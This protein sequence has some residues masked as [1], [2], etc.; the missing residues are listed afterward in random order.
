[1]LLPPPPSSWATV[2]GGA[3]LARPTLKTM[4]PDTGCPSP[5]HGLV[6]AEDDLGGRLAHRRA[7][8]RDG[9]LE[10]RVGRRGRRRR[11][12]QG[13]RE[14]RGASHQAST[15]AAPAAA[16]HYGD[17][18]QRHDGHD[19]EPDVHAGRRPPPLSGCHT[20][21]PRIAPGSEPTARGRRR[22][23]AAG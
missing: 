1:L 23:R 10:L 19:T 2:S 4:P 7:A 11:G 18:A 8:G 21:V 5:L 20:S 3:A 13:Q 15:G 6:E 22:P 12:E 17:D 16:A 14:Q 9:A